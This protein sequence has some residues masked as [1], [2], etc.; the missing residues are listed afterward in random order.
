MTWRI[1]NDELAFGSGEILVGNIYGNSLFPFR[2]Q[3]VGEQGQ[4][5]RIFVPVFPLF[6]QRFQL[7]GQNAFAVVQQTPDQGAFAIVHAA[8]R[9]KS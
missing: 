8:C 6:F 9:Y 4:V 3:P 5:N 1:R 2:P 7:I